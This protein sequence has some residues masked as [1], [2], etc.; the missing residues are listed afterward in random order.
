MNNILM[1][2]EAVCGILF[3]EENGAITQLS[4]RC[5]YSTFKLTLYS[6]YSSIRNCPYSGG[7]LAGVVSS[8]GCPHR[9]AL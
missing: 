1:T 8:M 7:G 5:I 4:R 2:K 6:E 9:V 3:R